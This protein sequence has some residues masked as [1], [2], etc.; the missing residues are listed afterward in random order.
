MTRPLAIGVDVGTSGIR[1]LAID[2]KGA[3]HA[4]ATRSMPAPM[5]TDGRQ[6]QSPTI[7]WDTLLDTLGALTRT[8]PADHQPR[9]LA[10]DGTSGSLL[11]AGRDGRALGPALMYADQRASTEAA[12]IAEL[13]PAESGAHGPSSALAKLLWLLRHQPPPPGFRALHQADWLLACLGAP[14]GT[15]D[16]NN[17]LKL[18]YDPVNRHWPEWL[19]RLGIPP[20]ALPEPRIPGTPVG[21]LNPSLAHTL[22]LPA[23]LTL[24]AGTTDGVAAF[25]ATG[26]NTPGEGVTSLGS[27]LVLKQLCSHPIFQAEAGI[28]SHRLGDLWLAGGAS[29]SGGAVLRAHFDDDEIAR[30]TQALRPEEPT[31]LDYYPLLRP[32]ERFPIA[33]PGLPPRLTPR[34]ADTCRFFQ[35]ML[36]GMAEIERQGYV[37]L[38]EAG[39]E[40]LISVRSV[41][42]GAINTGW[43]R[44]RAAHLGVPLLDPH[45]QDAA[46]G[47]ALLARRVL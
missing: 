39:G 10:L 35:G 38:R 45:H 26:A 23:G 5:G 21:T 43:T 6:E 34:P 27:T 33:D 12:H 37:R 25:I 29:N 18:G 15:S 30:C 13:A 24:V 3:I 22:G 42:G 19:A 17:A 40:P 32:G 31:A 14:L 16:E 36:E 9:A 46:Y 4:Q 7:W 28:Y 2:D 44:I 8:L 47:A 41:G 11:L 1:A 20:E